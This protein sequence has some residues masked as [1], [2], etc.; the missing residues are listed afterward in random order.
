M[1]VLVK[2]VACGNAVQKQLE[3]HAHDIP[4]PTGLMTLILP[5]L[6]MRL[7]AIGRTRVGDTERIVLSGSIED[8]ANLQKQGWHSCIHER[9]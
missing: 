4:H 5:G 8:L 7:V 9:Q 6:H 2:V 1:K 3:C